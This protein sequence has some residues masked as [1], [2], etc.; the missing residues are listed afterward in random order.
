[1]SNPQQTL[2]LTIETDTD[3]LEFIEHQDLHFWL[4]VNGCMTD[5]KIPRHISREVIYNY[6]SDSNPKQLM[7]SLTF[8]ISKY[9]KKRVQKILIDFAPQYFV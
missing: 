8:G 9:N 2:G 4:Y 5:V 1:M 6:R 7:D 3:T